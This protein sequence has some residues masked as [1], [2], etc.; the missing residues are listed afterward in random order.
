MPVITFE[1]QDLKDLGIDIEKD[2]L[3]NTLP[4]MGSDIEDYNDKEIKVEFFPNRPDNLSIEGVARS[5]KG[6]LSMETG[7]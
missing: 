2:K 4:M 3:I 1:Y 7:L 5:L 6:F